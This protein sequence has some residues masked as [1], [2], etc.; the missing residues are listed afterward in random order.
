MSSAS[1]TLV[2]T[3][4]CFDLPD[5]VLDYLSG[6]Q[7]TMKKLGRGVRWIRPEGIHL[8]LKFLGDVEVDK[9]QTIAT[10]IKLA[11]EDIAPVILH[12]A[13]TGAFPGDAA[14]PCFYRFA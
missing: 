5:M 7:N 1:E 4:I 12:L 13:G 14:H 10:A 9:I 2:R 11:S 8:T 6:L 3:F